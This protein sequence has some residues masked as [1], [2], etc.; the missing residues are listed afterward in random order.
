M[1][2]MVLLDGAEDR[3]EG[4]LRR[5]GAVEDRHACFKRVNRVTLAKSGKDSLVRLRPDRP[6]MAIARQSGD[7]IPV[8][9]VYNDG[10][11]MFGSLHLHEV[12]RLAGTSRHSG[13][14]R[15]HSYRRAVS[16]P[17]GYDRRVRPS[18]RI[19]FRKRWPYDPERARLGCQTSERLDTPLPNRKLRIASEELLERRCCRHDGRKEA[20]RIGADV[21]P[22]VRGTVRYE[23]ECSR[24]HRADGCAELDAERSLERV[25]QFVFIVDVKRWTLPRGGDRFECRERAAACVACDL[26][27]KTPPTGFSTDDP[28]PAI[29]TTSRIKAI[30]STCRRG[31]LLSVRREQTYAVRSSAISTS[32]TYSPSRQ[33]SPR[34]T[35][36]TANPVRS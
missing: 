8:I 17:G 34:S 25:D 35:P 30:L 29:T 4:R 13:V 15:E 12:S 23:D 6:R 20:R 27:V 26:E 21:L 7:P 10:H 16:T 9:R 11:A 32:S 5:L 14:I 1:L 22:G 31:P 33:N 3:E 19:G 28:P 2:A 24:R 36:S 18:E